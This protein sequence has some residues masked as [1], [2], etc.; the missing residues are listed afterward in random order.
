MRSDRAVI[1]IQAFAVLYLIMWTVSPPL[2]IGNAWRL[3]AMAS[4]TVW[5][6]LAFIR[7]QIWID[8]TV[9]MALVFGLLGAIV[10]LVEF[11]AKGLILQ[12]SLYM[13][14]LCYLIFRSYNDRDGFN[15]L[16]WII[17]V[18]LIA[19]AF[20]NYRSATAL[21]EDAH[22]ARAM[23][24]DDSSTYSYMRQGIGGYG[25]VYAQVIVIPAVLRWTEIAFRKAKVSFFIGCVYL[26]TCVMLLQEAGYTIAVTSVILG[27]IVLHFFKNKR[28]GLLLVAM[29][30]LVV[31]LEYALLHFESF[32]K[33]VLDFFAGSKVET[34]IN[35]IIAA[36]T[37]GE[38]SSSIDSRISTYLTSIRVILRYPII[39]G[40][41][42][43]G[44]GGH[45]AILDAFAKYGLFGGIAFIRLYFAAPN[46]YRRRY[47][48]TSSYRVFNASLVPMFIVALL[49]S[50]PYNMIAMAL[51]FLPIL[52]EDILRR[53]GVKE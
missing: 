43:S 45:S 1:R 28:V 32:Q 37:T 42:W 34:R 23:A 11:G 24:R 20:Y 40:L 33:V 50:V 47:A 3:L 41:G 30:L 48:D 29:V 36:S 17:P 49:N 6:F 13:L 19:L 35:E 12:I 4:A 44:G 38:T 7:R 51:L 18:V 53:E 5:I 10:S 26:M 31:G 9:V 14:V 2:W 22:I 25:L 52:Y 39:G 27:V 16:K 15:E 21:A 46:E 8:N